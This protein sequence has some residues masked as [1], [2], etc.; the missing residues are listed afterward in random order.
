MNKYMVFTHHC[1]K[2]FE[3]EHMEMGKWLEWSEKYSINVV[4]MGAPFTDNYLL[5]ED[6]TYTSALTRLSGY[7]ILQGESFEEIR[8]ILLD[9]PLYPIRGNYDVE[10]YDLMKMN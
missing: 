7:M 4:D 6:G 2:G 10:V 8:E 5:N 9:S 1:E 3:N